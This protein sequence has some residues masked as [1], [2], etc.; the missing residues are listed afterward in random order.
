MICITYVCVYFYQYTLN[1]RRS[2]LEVSKSCWKPHVEK[3]IWFLKSREGRELYRL[4]MLFSSLT[5][6][7]LN[8][9]QGHRTFIALTHVFALGSVTRC[10]R[11]RERRLGSNSLCK[12]AFARLVVNSNILQWTAGGISVHAHTVIFTF[13]PN[14]FRLVPATMKFDITL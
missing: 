7:Q 10:L 3:Y 9:E 6:N 8:E 12:L 11:V 4:R 5:S 13:F 2:D 14:Q 1:M